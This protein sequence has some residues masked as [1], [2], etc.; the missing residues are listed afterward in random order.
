MSVLRSACVCIL[1]VIGLAVW[2]GCTQEEKLHR[3]SGN[4]T[5]DGKPI[6]K[7]IISFVPRQDGPQGFANI[8]DGKYDTAKEGKGV[9]GGA[10]DIRVNGF[11]G[12]KVADAPFGN[13]LFPEYNGEKE[14]PAED[15]TFDLEI[16]K[17]R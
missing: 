3:V 13:A 4:V 1:F 17:K 7:G 16:P 10:Y 5:F 6:A 12:K 9:R 2:T 14:L 8:W 15:S 11:D